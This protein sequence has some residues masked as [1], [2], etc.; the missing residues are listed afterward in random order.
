VGAEV[1]S[2]SGRK[3][4]RVPSEKKTGMP[5]VCPVLFY[6]G[7][8][9][10]GGE[11]PTSAPREKEVVSNRKEKTNGRKKHKKGST[12][13]IKPSTQRNCKGRKKKNVKGGSNNLNTGVKPVEKVPTG[14]GRG[15]VMQGGRARIQ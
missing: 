12:W 7:K 2:N 1:V 5:A 13:K 9:C 8:K 4:K 3:K 10:D 15:V 11:V 14:G 6:M